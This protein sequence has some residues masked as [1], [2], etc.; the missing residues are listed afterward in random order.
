MK[1][2]A[3]TLK[4]LLE[5]NVLEIKF[6]RRRPKPGGVNTRRMLCTNNPIILQSEGGHRT[7]HYK[8]PSSTPKY[9]PSAKGLVLA[10]DILKQDYRAIS[11]DNCQIISQMPVTGDGQDFW[12]YFN[13][14]IHP[15]TP[16]EKGTFFNV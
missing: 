14:T 10:W 15:M 8:K 6:K 5:N 2:G 12:E 13:S 7:L 16:G 9:N 1:V 4:V 11:T 3:S